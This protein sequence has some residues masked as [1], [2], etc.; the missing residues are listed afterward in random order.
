MR[1]PFRALLFL[2]LIPL[3]VVA[4]LSEGLVRNFGQTK[5]KELKHSE[6]ASGLVYEYIP[7]DQ[8]SGRWTEKV[9]VQIYPGK[10]FSLTDFVK[11]FHAL[12]QEQKD[13]TYHDQFLLNKPDE[14]IIEWSL[15]NKDNELETGGWLRILKDDKA[16]KAINVELK[17]PTDFETHRTHWVQEIK[18]YDFAPR[19]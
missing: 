15:L 16:L 6:D 10:N 17:K 1:L 13:M 14:K 8:E 5:W 7:A 12:M 19:I 3:T 18:S 9:T 11:Q 4:S 2:V